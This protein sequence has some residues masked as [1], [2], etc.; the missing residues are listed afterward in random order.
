MARDLTERQRILL[1]FIIDYITER[2]YPP[3]IREMA[4]FMGIK[5]NTGVIAHLK[6]L[7]KKGYIYKTNS[8]S[9]GISLKGGVK[10][11]SGIRVIGKVVAGVPLL[12]YENIEEIL[13]LS[14]EAFGSSNNKVFGLKVQGDSMREAGI[15]EGDI[16]F[17]VPDLVP[18][19]GDI[20]V[21]SIDGETTV[22]YFYKNSKGVIMLKAANKDFANIYI[23]ENQINELRIIGKVIGLFRRFN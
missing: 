13:P 12:S 6:A 17:V 2:G 9:R 20:V 15:M 18:S 23:S 21:A 7:E 22:K 3:S 4:K 19:N 5:S 1:E 16:V 10:V 14:P 11:S 8:L